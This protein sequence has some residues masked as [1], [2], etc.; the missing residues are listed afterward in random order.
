VALLL[1]CDLGESFGAWTM[2]V[3]E[4]VMPYIDQANIACGF[5]AGDPVVINKTLTLA[6]QHGVTVGAH[7]S[8]PDL[9]GFGRRS[10]NCSTEEIQALLNYQIAALDG[11]ACNH[12]LTLRYVKPHG[13]LYNDMM[14]RDDI[15]QTIMQT[16]AAYHK[17]LHLMLQATAAAD[18]HR[19][20]AEAY[21]LPLYFEAFADR[22]YDDDGLLLA[23]SKAGAVLNHDEMLQQVQQLQDSQTV[24]TVSG[25]TLPLAADTLCVHGDNQAG[26]NAINQI[27]QLIHAS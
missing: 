14:K 4:A 23:R 24:T 6:K 5:H 21:Q 12:G 25:K 11:M 1:N 7:P 15:R 3:D 19:R 20:E 18:K 9:A 16:I 27:R 17:P 13:A 22:R 26:V 2:G 8:Y 10:M